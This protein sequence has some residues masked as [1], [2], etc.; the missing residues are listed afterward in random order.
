MCDSGKGELQ[1]FWLTSVAADSENICPK[2]S[3]VCPGRA[4]HF[5]DPESLRNVAS[6]IRC[7][8][9]YSDQQVVLTINKPH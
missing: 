9:S 5:I 6:D 8:I 2:S 7:S 3:K 1:T 4:T